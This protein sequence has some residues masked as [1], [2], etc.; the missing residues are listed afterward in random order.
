M[1]AGVG[2]DWPLGAVMRR[3]GS[4]TGQQHAVSDEKP[5]EQRSSYKTF[6]CTQAQVTQSYNSKH[7]LDNVR[8]NN[9]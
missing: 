6:Q 7:R 5:I 4:S 8:N 3:V 2:T 9:K 1:G